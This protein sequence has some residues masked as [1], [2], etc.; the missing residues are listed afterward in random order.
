MIPKEVQE[1]IFKQAKADQFCSIEVYDYIK[2]AIQH[3]GWDEDSEQ[4]LA[5]KYLAVL[6]ECQIQTN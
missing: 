2:T 3:F 5:L 4:A 6:V 1:W